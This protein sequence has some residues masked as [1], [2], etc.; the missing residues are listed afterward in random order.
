[1]NKKIVDNRLFSIEQIKAAFWE[2]FHKA[3]ELW[4]DY[5]G[6]EENNENSTEGHWQDFLE[7]LERLG[8]NNE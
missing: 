8:D 1:M 6:D 3:G 7:T 5:L 4:F 2:E